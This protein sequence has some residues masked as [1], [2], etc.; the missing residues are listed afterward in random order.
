MAR[1]L[2]LDASSYRPHWLHGEDRIWQE[3]NCAADLWIEALHALGL[4]PLLG[5]AFTLS[6]DFDGEQWQMFTFPP[7]DLRRLFGIEM[8]ELNVW[9]PLADHLVDQLSL[10]HLVVVD[11]DA[12]HLP[13]TAGLT[14]RCA[15]Q[16]TSVMVQHI[17][18]VERRLGYFHNAGYYELSGEDYAG[19]LEPEAGS[20]AAS[21]PPFALAI[22]LERLRPVD[23]ATAEAAEALAAEHLERRARSN[24]VARLKKRIEE[25]LPWLQ[26]K[27]LDTFHRY[28]FGT[29]RQCGS[30]A[31]LAASF[32]SWLGARHGRISSPAKKGF[33][34]LASSMK[35]IEFSL[36]R[37][38]RGR[39]CDLDA[40]FAGPEAA[41]ERAMVGLSDLGV[42]A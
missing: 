13:D 3:T 18:P 36:A 31:E 32:S 40:L 30:G 21:L 4:D 14:Y 20:L 11:V 5:L 33:V 23:E 27:G 28:A 35:S 41:W 1:V 26:A 34:E 25:D 29:L 19:I 37:A 22:R 9:R 2:R 7:E 24:P 12:W 39:P 16:K 38:A 42:A 6:A 8:D 17:D 15:H 10:R